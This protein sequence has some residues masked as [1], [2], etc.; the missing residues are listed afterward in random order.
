ML[1]SLRRGAGT[2]VAKIFMGL[3]VLSFAVWGIPA[4]NFSD[5][6]EVATVGDREITVPEFQRALRQQL[7]ALSIRAGRRLTLE[8]ARA[9]G[10]DR[11]VMAT[12]INGAAVD[13]HARELNLGI[14]DAVIATRIKTARE[15]MGADGEFNERQFQEILRN[16]NLS[17]QGFVSRQKQAEVRQQLSIA[18][19]TGLQPP[20][21]LLD[22]FHRYTGEVRTASFFTF[23]PDKVAKIAEPKDAE[24]KK[25]YDQNKSRFMTPEYRRLSMLV[26]G[27]DDVKKTISVSEPDLKAA[28]E[29]QKASF[30]TPE[31]RR[32]MQLV[33]SDAAGAEAAAK[34]LKSGKTFAEVAKGLGRKESEYDLGTVA[35]AG[36]LDKKLAEAAFKLEKD[37][38]SDPVAGSFATALLLVTDVTPAK[39]QTFKE[40]RA[41]LLQSL[42]TERA[43][44]E[45]QVLHDKIEDER[46]AG[47]TLK[48]IA[49]ALNIKHLAIN[50]I[51]RDGKGTDGKLAFTHTQSA[52]ILRAAFEGREGVEGEVVDL[53]DGGF[54]WV[55]VVSVTK[56][57]QKDLKTVKAEVIE[58]LKAAN[59]RKKLQAVA[60]DVIKR[61]KSGA[62]MEA[63]AKEIGGAVQTT[64]PLSRSGR[65][66]ILGR[67]AISQIFALRE[68]SFGS[69]ATP[70]GRSRILFKVTKVTPPP[71]ATKQVKERQVS[72]LARQLSDDVMVQYIASLEGRFGVT[73]NQ[74]ALRAALGLTEPHY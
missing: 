14:S 23:D 64:Q 66:P 1:E 13:E 34:Q 7:D 16:N 68:G 72:E 52:P 2:W 44:P 73:V 33:F 6:G 42:Q 3:L 25:H 69:V 11:S 49:A 48:E 12:L 55:D 26:L 31:K 9:F 20:K 67:P 36:M 51:A 74:A 60:T 58:Q 21:P 47:K 8:Q 17:E 41:K 53:P 62:T 18:M 70:D 10:I 38:V 32:V 24:I 4:L 28:Y 45:V 35:K 43:Q 19:L 30:G 65:H 54:A 61:L 56:P 5:H 29:A 59:L 63:V 15:F 40:V 57:K 27:V 46:A 37:K 50:A 71:A 22:A 39:Q